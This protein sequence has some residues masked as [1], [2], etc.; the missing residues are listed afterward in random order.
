MSSSELNNSQGEMEVMTF[1]YRISKSRKLLWPVILKSALHPKYFHQNLVQWRD[2]S[3]SAFGD[4]NLKF[5]NTSHVFW[6]VYNVGSKGNLNDW[7][8]RNKSNATS[9]WKWIRYSQVS[10]AGCLLCPLLC[11][12]SCCTKWIGILQIGLSSMKYMW[13]VCLRCTNVTSLLLYNLI[14]WWLNISTFIFH[15]SLKCYCSMSCK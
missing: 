9:H 8:S 7:L 13:L 14:K 3:L 6:L 2:W 4:F 1:L 15:I 11:I 5:V 12:I 10:D